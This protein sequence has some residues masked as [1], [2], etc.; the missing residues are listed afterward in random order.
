MTKFRWV[1]LFLLFFA[2]SVNYLDRMVMGILAPDLQ[3]AY[4]ITD[5]D[6]ARINSAFALSYAGGQL[7]C[8]RFLDLIG[9]N[10]VFALAL[11]GG[12]IASIS[13]AF[14][15]PAFVFG[16]PRGLLGVAESPIFPAS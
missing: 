14:A 5:V 6:Y 13:H 7:F 8:G 12:S 15:R 16:P 4:N 1:I 3:K 10:L 2:T 9:V 11:V